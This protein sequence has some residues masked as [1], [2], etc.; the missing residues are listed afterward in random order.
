MHLG[1]EK[2]TLERVLSSTRLTHVKLFKIDLKSKSSLLVTV[3]IC[4][5]VFRA[6]MQAITYN[7]TAW[8]YHRSHAIALVTDD[9]GACIV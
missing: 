2:R 8:L 3:E 9:G 6:R 7:D 5:I 4:A 1:S